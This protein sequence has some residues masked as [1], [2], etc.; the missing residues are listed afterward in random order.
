MGGVVC[1]VR[2]GVLSTLCSRF[3][4]WQEPACCAAAADAAAAAGSTAC[5]LPTPFADVQ[6]LGQVGC[7]VHHGTQDGTAAGLICNN[8]G[9]VAQAGGK[10]SEWTSRWRVCRWRCHSRCC[11]VRQGAGGNS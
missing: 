5:C 2:V 1:R 7:P 4:A 10:Q 8:T 3:N 6:G 11:V 9:V